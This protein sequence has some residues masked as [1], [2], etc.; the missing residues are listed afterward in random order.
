MTKLVPSALLFATILRADFDPARWQFR[1]TIQL[2]CAAPI[3]TVKIDGC[4]YRGSAARLADIRVVR[5]AAERPYVLE[6][7]RGSFEEKE[8]Q[9]SVLNKAAVPGVGVEVTLD[10]GA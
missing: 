3:A 1:R 6:A 7:L 9:P 10:L 8:L 2:D 4:V 5:S